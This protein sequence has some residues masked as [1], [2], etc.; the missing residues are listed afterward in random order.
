MQE[1]ERG[2]RD[3]GSGDEHA[4]HMADSTQQRCESFT[5]AAVSSLGRE[6]RATL[7]DGNVFRGNLGENLAARPN[8]STVVDQADAKSVDPT[9]A[10][11]PAIVRRQRVPFDWT[12]GANVAPDDK[13]LAERAAELREQY[14]AMRGD[15]MASGM[16]MLPPGADPSVACVVQ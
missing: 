1:K 7:S 6:A 3:G 15:K 16:A 4:P 12:V 11:L 14:E 5:V 13:S 10:V 9:R 8:S 2:A